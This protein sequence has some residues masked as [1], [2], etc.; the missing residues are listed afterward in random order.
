MKPAE[1]ILSYRP[2]AL[3]RASMHTIG[4]FGI[5]LVTQIILLF[6]LARYLGPSAFGE[7]AAIAAFAVLL[8]AIS[9]LGIGFLV[10]IDTAHSPKTGLQ[11]YKKA[12]PIT[13]LSA[14]LLL[15]LYLIISHSVIKTSAATYILMMIGLSE[16][17]AIPLI[18]VQAQ[19]CQGL[20]CVGQ[21]QLLLI[22]PLVSRLLLL[23]ILTGLV[24]DGGLL[25]FAGIHLTTS[26]LSLGVGIVL[27]GTFQLNL[28]NATAIDLPTV[29]KSVPY[30]FMR[31]ASLGPGEIDK[32]IAPRLI[33]STEAGAYAMATRGLAVATLPIIALMLVVQ[34][35]IL[36]TAP[37]HQDKI[38]I[39]TITVLTG[40]L[41]YGVAIGMLFYNIAPSIFFFLLGDAFS[42]TLDILRLLALVAPLLTFRVALGGLLV[43]YE[44]PKTRTIV[45]ATGTVTLLVIAML[46]VP[47]MSVVGFVLAIGV[48]EAIMVLAFSG[49]LL[50][51]QERR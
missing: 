39:L 18:T 48:S 30:A 16:L 11:T 24:P 14:C 23:T 37:P 3:A 43:A 31:L 46:V 29:R 9:S 6:L 47:A 27:V 10:L 34:P 32:T 21:G 45:E 12:L 36:S 1:V 2:G 35:R 22:A 8:G 38:R 19:R 42:V 49:T 7:Y 51:Q 28:I 50:L 20:G 17:I 41:L 40:S 15:P 33:G 4:L 13:L 26:L 5:R 25:Y 44:M